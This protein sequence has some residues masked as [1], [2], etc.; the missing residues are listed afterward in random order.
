MLPFD[1]CVEITSLEPPVGPVAVSRQHAIG[2]K[3]TQ[4][5]IGEQPVHYLLGGEPFGLI[6]RG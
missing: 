3:T 6:A 1:P 5:H 2:G 4:L